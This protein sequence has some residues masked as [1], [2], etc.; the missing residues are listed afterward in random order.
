M[1]RCKKSSFLIKK[2][3]I[4]C[5]VSVIF[6]LQDQ[7]HA[8]H[9]EHSALKKHEISWFFFRDHCPSFLAA[10]RDLNQLTKLNPDS[11]TESGSGIRINNM[12]E[13]FAL[14]TGFDSRLGQL[15]DTFGYKKWGEKGGTLLSHKL[16]IEDMFIRKF[17]KV[18]RFS[19]RTCSSG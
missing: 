7:T 13:K 9:I 17:L 6:K 1:H 10:I 12:E 5:F 14:L 11:R 15:E 4:Y 8:L 2:N 3:S 18:K 19:S 16:F